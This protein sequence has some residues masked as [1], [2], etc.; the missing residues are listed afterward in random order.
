LK[1]KVNKNR[2]PE[3]TL[4]SS[5]RVAQRNRTR[6]AIIDAAMQLMVAGSMPSMAAVAQAAQVSRRT[7][8]MYFP[9]L[10]QL[11]IDATLGA[12]AQNAI[13]PILT[14]SI[15]SDAAVRMEQLSRILSRNSGET[16]HLGR[17]LLRLTV[18]GEQ[19]AP[20]VPR[21]G[22]RRVEWIERAVAPAREQLTF[23]EFKRMV[24]ALCV[25]TGWE[26]MIVLQDVRCL[27]PMEAGDVLAFAASAVVEKALRE[28]KRR[29]ERPGYLHRDK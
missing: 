5:G 14:E 2:K 20:G 7:I 22:Y 21:R 19:P 28:S 24:S 25:L 13:E 26:P 3:Q 16:M 27:D 1:K 6:K 12:L 8:Y 10:D 18:E 4:P 15:S 17:A 23:A 11:L 9:T 29:G